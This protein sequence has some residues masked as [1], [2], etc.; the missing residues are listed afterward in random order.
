M[1]QGS[2]GMVA[3]RV[4]P[5]PAIHRRRRAPDGPEPQ[6]GRTRLRAP[7]PRTGGVSGC[8]RADALRAAASVSRCHEPGT[9]VARRRDF[10]SLPESTSIGRA[11][12]GAAV[13]RLD[14]ETRGNVMTRAEFEADLRQE[15]Y[16]VR[17]GEVCKPNEH[18]EAHAPTGSRDARVLVLDGSIT[19]VFGKQRVTYG[20]GDS[21]SVPAGTVRGAHGRRRRALRLRSAPGAARGRRWIVGAAQP[22]AGETRHLAAV[23]GGRPGAAGGADGRGSRWA[24]LSRWR[25]W[26]AVREQPAAQSTIGAAQADPGVVV[27]QTMSIKAK[28]DAVHAASRRHGQ[29]RQSSGQ[30]DHRETTPGAHRGLAPPRR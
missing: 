9:R 8:G 23:V 27:G 17:E 2:R 14:A 6:G 7:A 10:S 22:A 12:D 20:P 24:C 1:R 25:R 21:C 15:G 5:G 16:E 4:A 29:W 28:P 26:T 19:L 30:Q 18:R 3:F 11:T 13:E